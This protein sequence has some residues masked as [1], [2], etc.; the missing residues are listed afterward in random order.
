MRNENSQTQDAPPKRTLLVVTRYTPLS[1]LSGAGTYLFSILSYL[2][3]HGVRVYLCWSERPPVAARRGWW[4]VPREMA[5]IA[6]LLIPGAVAIGR[7]RIFPSVFLGP[8]KARLRQTLKTAARKLG[9][10]PLLGISPP[11]PA[12]EAPPLKP[13]SPADPYAWDRSPDDYEYAFFGHSIANIQPD[14]L[15]FNYC[16]MTPIAQSLPDPGRY[17]KITLT[18][19]LRHIYSTL[20][21]G[22]IRWSEGE[23]MSKEVETNYLRLTDLVV[24]IRE[25]DAGIFRGLLPGKEVVVASPALDPHPG[26]KAPLPDRCLFVAADNLANREGLH[27]FL[28]QAWPQVRAANPDA[29]LHICGTLCKTLTITQPGVELLGFV[30][31]LDAVYEEAS[32]VIVPLLRGSGV[33]IKL[34]EALARGK[35]CVSTPIGAEGIPALDSCVAIAGTADAFATHV[36]RLLGDAAARRSL[37]ER[38]MATV[39]EHFSAEACYGPLRKSLLAPPRRRP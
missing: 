1:G 22:E 28:E 31:S 32:V 13:H 6:T 21:E 20:V 4:M 17:L 33:K 34:M 18:H 10:G 25:D 7:L 23:A 37:E 5:Q 2:H 15:L 27:W 11:G 39:R 29:H 26:S 19:D 16:W 3:R 9:L 30:E 12:A 14:A 36:L 24:A 38:A 35:A 8:L